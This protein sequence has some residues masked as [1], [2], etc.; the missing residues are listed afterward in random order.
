MRVREHD[1][2]GLTRFSFPNQSRPQ[3]IITFA[4][5]YETNSDVCIRCRCERALIFAARAQ[6]LTR[7]I[8]KFD[9]LLQTI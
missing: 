2:M 6:R 3:S 4:S 9:K 5:R 8:I 7:Q 1:R